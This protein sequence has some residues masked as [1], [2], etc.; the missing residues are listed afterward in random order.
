[1]RS[2]VLQGFIYI[3]SRLA[4]VTDQIRVGMD[5]VSEGSRHLPVLGVGNVGFNRCI[6]QLTD[7]WCE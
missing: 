3:P 4:Y 6:C 7:L 5:S 2:L 1:M